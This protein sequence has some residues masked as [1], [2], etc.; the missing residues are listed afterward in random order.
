[1]AVFELREALKPWENQRILVRGTL[2]D[3]QPWTV[4]PKG[5]GM[6]GTFRGGRPSLRACIVDPEVEGKVVCRHVWV[7]AC[8]HWEKYKDRIG[9]DIMFHATVK[10]YVDNKHKPAQT[11][12]CLTN[13]DEP[14][15]LN[16][17]ALAIPH[18]NGNGPVLPTPSRLP[19]ATVPLAPKVT[20]MKIIAPKV[21]EAKAELAKLPISAPP[22]IDLASPPLPPPP[23][24]VPEPTHPVIPPHIEPPKVTPVPAVVTP[25]DAMKMMKLAKRF[26]KICGH[27]KA[28]AVLEFV[29][30][31]PGLDF[32]ELLVWVDALEEE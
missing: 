19:P 24:I 11:N 31:N 13:A 17:P 8:G 18:T 5:T 12:W 26:V 27:T 4:Q 1:M 20:P 9:E 28:K 16:S 3:F 15:F 25:A 22:K 21:E 30:E 6:L 23:P 14:S 7:I 29:K 10:S 2:D 32:G